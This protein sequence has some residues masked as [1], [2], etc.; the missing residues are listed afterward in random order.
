MRRLVIALVFVACSSETDDGG[1]GATSAAT[2]ASSGS[3]STSTNGESSSTSTGTTGTSTDTTESGTE[4]TTNITT[5]ATDSSSSETGPDC[6]APPDCETCWTCASQGACKTAYSTCEAD[7][8]CIPS[9]YCIYTNCT[10]DGLQQTCADDCCKSCQNTGA[11]PYVDAA[12]S[13]IEQEC[14]GL[15]GDISCP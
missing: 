8:G 15:C 10:E 6:D 9:L 14:A 1:T 4:S 7:V 11:C 3:E 5:T 12:I 13:C 2:T